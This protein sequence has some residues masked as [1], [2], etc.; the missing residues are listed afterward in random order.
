MDFSDHDLQL[1]I[2]KPHGEPMGIKTCGVDMAEHHYHQTAVQITP[3]S[4]R[5]TFVIKTY[6]RETGKTYG[7]AMEIKTYGMGLVEH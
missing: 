2:D 7:K 4:R 3:T 1:E 6:G 5:W